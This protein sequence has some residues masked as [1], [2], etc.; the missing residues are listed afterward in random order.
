MF[1]IVF[2]TSLNYLHNYYVKCCIYV[3]FNI[4]VFSVSLQANPV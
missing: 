1:V 3:K 4:F 2:E